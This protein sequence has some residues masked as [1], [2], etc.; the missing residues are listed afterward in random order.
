M[1]VEKLFP[2]KFAKKMR[3]D[4]LETTFSVYPPNFGYFED[5]FNTHA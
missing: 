2:A 4:T 1:G 5:F 3:Q